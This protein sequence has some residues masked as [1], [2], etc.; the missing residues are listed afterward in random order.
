MSAAGLPISHAFILIVVF[1]SA[2]DHR[3]FPVSLVNEIPGHVGRRAKVV[4]ADSDIELFFPQNPCLEDRAN[5]A[6][7]ILTAGTGMGEIVTRDSPVAMDTSFSA[8]FRLAS[9][10]GWPI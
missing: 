5:E 2:T 3:Y 7:K 8:I 6:G 1:K 10:T 9:S 4:L